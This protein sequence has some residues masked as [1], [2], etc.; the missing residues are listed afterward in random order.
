MSQKLF[1]AFATLLLSCFSIQIPLKQGEFKCM[2]VYAIGH[3]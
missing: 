2:L 3:D 1:I